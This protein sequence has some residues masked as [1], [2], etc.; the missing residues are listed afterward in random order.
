[1][2]VSV[3]PDVVYR[4][5]LVA[6][7]GRR[8]HQVVSA[9]GAV[10][11]EADV[12][13]G[14]G[15]AR[16]VVVSPFAA[17]LEAALLAID[18]RHVVGVGLVPTLGALLTS[19]ALAEGP[20]PRE[21]H[22]TY[23]L[24]LGR[25]DRDTTLAELARRAL[26]VE[27]VVWHEGQRRGESVAEGRRLAWFPQPLGA[28]HA[29]SAPFADPVLVRRLAPVPTVTVGV[30]LRSWV[31]EVVQAAGRPGPLG[32]RLA[33]V[34]AGSGTDVDPG[35]RADQRW[36]VVVEVAREDGITR[37]WANGTDLATSHAEVV[38]AVAERAVV[39]TGTSPVELGATDLLDVLADRGVLRW[40]VRRPD[41]A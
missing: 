33:G 6:T 25:R 28:H 24:P 34:V 10:A 20:E 21:V 13:T 39:E 9:G 29:A 8:G 1:M 3:G 16:Q 37:S 31:A 19:A 35:R 12:R 7:L 15:A 4:D 2:E 18:A 32:R 5:D 40:V 14:D 38:T 22:V 41:R 17:D 27:G 30:S 36:A 26:V 23:H 11:V